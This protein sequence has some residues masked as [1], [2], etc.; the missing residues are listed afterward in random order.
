[1][2]CVTKEAA[3]AERSQC[4]LKLMSV[5]RKDAI[6]ARR[7]VDAICNGENPSSFRWRHVI[8]ALAGSHYGQDCLVRLMRNDSLA[9]ERFSDLL[10]A[11]HGVDDPN[12]RLVDHL[13]SVTM[14]TT[15]D[16]F[17]MDSRHAAAL[18]LGRLARKANERGDDPIARD[19]VAHLEA[20]LVACPV[21]DS[22]ELWSQFDDHAVVYAA[23]LGN[24]GHDASFVR[25]LEFAEHNQTNVRRAA[26]YG[27][28]HMTW[29]KVE[30]VYVRI[31]VDK[32]RTEA[33][34]LA[35]MDAMLSHA[36]ELSGEGVEALA[37][38]YHES[39][40][41]Y[42][43]VEKHLK[44]FFSTRLDDRSR[45]VLQRGRILTTVE[46]TKQRHLTRARRDSKL[47]QFLETALKPLVDQAFG[48]N[49]EFGKDFGA[50]KVKARFKAIFRNLAR[51]Y[52]SIFD[53]RVE[54]DIFNDVN[55][56]VSAFGLRF[57]IVHG[58]AAFQAGLSFKNTILSNLLN[59]VIDTAEKAVGS[60]RSA[61]APL[62]KFVV[63]ILDF[64]DDTFSSVDKILEPVLP[65]LNVMEQAIG[66]LDKAINVSNVAVD[67][68]N[69]I[70]S[71]ISRVGDLTFA[72]EIVQDLKDKL[73][74]FV[75]KKLQKLSDLCHSIIRYVTDPIDTLNEFVENATRIIDQITAIVDAI[76]EDVSAEFGKLLCD[77]ASALLNYDDSVKSDEEDDTGLLASLKGFVAKLAGVRGGGGS[78]PTM[79]LT[80]SPTSPGGGG[81]SSSPTTALTLSPTSP[82]GGGG[83]SSPTTASPGDSSSSSSS[84]QEILDLSGFFDTFIDY[85]R[86]LASGFRDGFKEGEA[87]GKKLAEDFKVFVGKMRGV[88]VSSQS[89]IDAFRDQLSGYTAVADVADFVKDL[90]KKALLNPSLVGKAL[91]PVKTAIT[92]VEAQVCGPIEK[93]LATVNRY[94]E[95]AVNT[96]Q[97]AVANL[98]D[99][100][101]G[102]LRNASAQVFDAFPVN[103]SLLSTV[104]LFEIIQDLMTRSI[105]KVSTFIDDAVMTRFNELAENFTNSIRDFIDS[106]IEDFA[107]VIDE[108]LKPM[109]KY[110]NASEEFIKFVQMA[111]DVNDVVAFVGEGVPE[112]VSLTGNINDVLDKT[113]DVAKWINEILGHISSSKSFVE[114]A[115]KGRDFV[116]GLIDE[117]FDKLRSIL[118]GMR[119][120]LLNSL[121]E[122]AAVA[123][124]YLSGG[125][126]FV[127]NII[128][129]ITSV[130]NRVN[131]F[132]DSIGLVKEAANSV[133]LSFEASCSFSG[134]VDIV[135][136]YEEK[137][138]G[139]ITCWNDLVNATTDTIG[140][141]LI[142]VTKTAVSPIEALA[143]KISNFIGRLI[144]LTDVYFTDLVGYVTQVCGDGPISPVCGAE[145]FI[146]DVESVIADAQAIVNDTKKIADLTAVVDKVNEYVERLENLTQR[147]IDKVTAVIDFAKSVSIADAVALGKRVLD[148]LLGGFTFEINLDLPS[149]PFRRRR[150][151]ISTD[152]LPSLPGRLRRE[153]D[154]AGFPF[155][156]EL[157]QLVQLGKTVWYEVRDVVLNAVGDVLQVANNFANA[158]RQM[159]DFFTTLSV[160]DEIFDPVL[161]IIN[162][163]E[164]LA[165]KLQAFLEETFFPPLEAATGVVLKFQSIVF[166]IK[167][168]INGQ[169][170][171]RIRS[172]AEFLS[173][174]APEILKTVRDW[175]AKLLLVDAG[176]DAGDLD[177][178]T[179]LDYCSAD[180]CVNVRPRS[181]NLYRNVVFKVKYTHLQVLQRNRV[182]IPGLFEDYQVEGIWPLDKSG[183]HFILSM[184][185]TGS[186]FQKP[187][188]LVV[189]KNDGTVLRLYRLYKPNGKILQGP[190]GVVI[191]E[192]WLYV[193]KINKTTKG[194]VVGNLY[195]ILK[196]ALGSMTTLSRPANVNFTLAENTDSMGTGMF[197]ENRRIWITDYLDSG[198]T[199]LGTTFP[200]HHIRRKNTQEAWVAA[201]RTDAKGKVAVTKY[202]PDK[203]QVLK[204]DRVVTVGKNVVGFSVFTQLG[205]T[206]YAIL[207]CAP[208][209]GFSCKLEFIEPWPGVNETY[210]GV[211]VRFGQAGVTIQRAVRM[212][213][214]AVDVTFVSAGEN[215]IVTFNSGAQGE[216]ARRLVTG[217]DLEDSTF[218]LAIPVLK[219]RLNIRDAVSRNELFLTVLGQD[220]VKPRELIPLTRSKR[221]TDLS[222]CLVGEGTLYEKE[223]EFFRTCQFGCKHR[224]I[225]LGV[226]FGIVAFLDFWALGNLEVTFQAA[227]CILEREARA[228]IIPRAYMTVGGQ[229]SIQA[230][231]LRVGIRIDVTL[232][233]TT[234]IPTLI[235]RVKGSVMQACGELKININP[236]SVT[237]SLVFDI[238]G[239]IIKCGSWK[240]WSCRIT[241]G[242]WYSKTIELFRW[243]ANTISLTPVPELCLSTPDRT[244]PVK[245]TV[246]AKQNDQQSL[247]AE[248]SDFTDPEAEYLHY[249]VT[250]R[251]TSGPTL[252]SNEFTDGA[253]LTKSGLT[254]QHGS[255]VIV[256]VECRNSDGKKTSVSAPSFFAD[257]TPPRVHGLV[258]G[259][260][261]S[262]DIDYG[263]SENSIKASFDQIT[264][265]TEVSLIEWGIGTTK[266]QDDVLA[267]AETK[268]SDDLA[269]NQLT[270]KHNT[271]YYVSIRAMNALGI[272]GITTTDGILIDHTN[273]VAGV[274]F[275]DSFTC[276]ED[277]D[278]QIAKESFK[279]CWMGF[280]DPES[281][282]H[283]YD[284]NLAHS[285]GTPEFDFIN[286]ALSSYGYIK[287]LNLI[288]KETYFVN[289]RAWNRAGLFTRVQSDGVLVDYTNPVCSQVFDVVDGVEGDS[290]YT[291]KLDSI[292]ATWTCSDPDSG[293][294]T[295]AA[296][297]GTFKGG[298][299]VLPF[300]D[301]GFSPNGTARVKFDTFVISGGVR[302]HVTSRVVNKAGL[303]STEWSD[304]ISLD[305]TP[306]DY[307]DIYVRD[308]AGAA[309]ALDVDF[310]V[311]DNTL[312]ARWFGAFADLQSP[313][314]T[315]YVTVVANNGSTIYEE[316]SIGYR[317]S[318]CVPDLSLETG[319]IYRV[320][321]RAENA[322]GLSTSVETDGVLIDNT[323]PMAGDL[324]DGQVVGED[325]DFWRFATS[326]FGN[327][328]S[329][330][331]YDTADFWPLDSLNLPEKQPCF[332]YQFR[333]EESGIGYLETNVI[334][335]TGKEMTTWQ[336]TEARFDWMGRTIAGVHNGFYRFA[337]RIYNGAGSFI[338]VY[339]NGSRIDTTPPEVTNLIE[340]NYTGV[341]PRSDIDYLTQDDIDVGASWD[342]TEDVS[343]IVHTDWAIGSYRGG[344]DWLDHTTVVGGD[345]HYMLTSLSLGRR[346]YIMVRV[347]NAAGLV[348]KVSTDGF[349]ID[350][351]AP[352]KGYVQDGWGEFDARYQSTNRTAWCKWRW[353]DDYESGIADMKLGIGSTLND[354]DDVY[355]EYKDLTVFDVAAERSVLTGLSLYSGILYYCH[356]KATDFVGLSTVSSSN[357]ITVDV[358]APICL[359]SVYEGYQNEIDFSAVRG[360]HVARWDECVDPDTDILQYL[361]G[362]ATNVTGPDLVL[363]YPFR[364]FGK[365]TVGPYLGV[366]L[367]H[368][369]TYYSAVR[370]VNFAGLT[371]TVISDGV[372]IDLTPPHCYSIGDGQEGDVD[373]ETQPGFIA[374]N[375]NCTEDITEINMTW[376]I[377]LY[378]G[379]S[380]LLRKYVDVNAG[381]A[382]NRDIILQEGVTLFSTLILLNTAG[383]RTVNTT[384]G[385][386]VDSTPPI[387][388]FVKDGLNTARD[389]DFQSSVSQI[390]ANWLISDI[391][392]GIL[393]YDVEIIPPP[394]S[395]N[396]VTKVVGANQVTIDAGLQPGG[397][398]QIKVTGYN[399]AGLFASATSDGI[400]IDP[401]PP[402]CTYVFDGARQGY[403]YQFQSSGAPLGVNWDCA[404]DESNITSIRWFAVN[405]KTSVSTEV[406]VD[407]D[408]IVAVASRLQL[409]EGDRFYARLVIENGAGLTKEFRSDGV[410]VDSSPPEI[411]DFTIV[412]D[413]T[414]ET[415]L[416]TWIA[417]D[418]ESGIAESEFGMGTEDGKYDVLALTSVGKSFSVSTK[419]YVVVTSP[420]TYYFYLVVANEASAK[421]RESA[422][423]VSDGTPPIFEG[424]VTVEIVYPA[425]NFADS[426]TFIDDAALLIVWQKISDV[427]TGVE[428]LSWALIN[429][430]SS[431]PDFKALTY[432]TL[433]DVLGGNSVQVDMIRLFNMNSY[434]VVLR[435][436]NGVGLQSYVASITFN[437]TFGAFKA[438]FVFDGPGY[439]DED[440]QPHTVGMWSRWEQF[441]DPVFGI[442]AY[443][444]G[445]GV[446]PNDTSILNLTNVELAEKAH[447]L[448]V[449]PLE[450]GVT[451]YITVVATNNRDFTVQAASDGITIDTT[452]A[453]CR[454]LGFG[455]SGNLEYVN[456]LQNVW[457][458]W[459]CSDDESP[460]AEYKFS[461]GT[462]AHFSDLVPQTT[463]APVNRYK[464]KT[465]NISEDTS[466]YLTLTVKNRAGLYFTETAGPVV[467]DFH[468]PNPGT[469][470][471]KWQDDKISAKWMDFRDESGLNRYEWAIGTSP[472]SANV[473]STASVG[474]S[475]SKVSPS[476][477]VQQGSLYYVTVTAYDM[478]ENFV[479]VQSAPVKGDLTV[480]VNGT[481]A[482][483][484]LMDEIDY[485]TGTGSIY[486]VWADFDDP[487]TGIAEYLVS[488]GRSPGASELQEPVSVGTATE[489]Y[490]DSERLTP[491]V[492][493]YVSVTAVNGIGLRTL[494]SSDGI[495]VDRTAPRAGSVAIEKTENSSMHFVGGTGPFTVKWKDF[496]DPES[497]IGYYV[498]SLCFEN[499]VEC[500]VPWENVQNEPEVVK[501]GLDLTPGQCYVARV[502]AYNKAGLWVQSMSESIVFDSTPPVMGTVTIGAKKHVTIQNDASAVT[503]VWSPIT[504]LDSGLQSITACIGTEP[505][506]C[507]VKSVDVTPTSRREVT[508]SGLSLT[509]AA[510]Y[511]AT[512]TVLNGA[513]LSSVAAS[514]GTIIDT[515]PPSVGTV[516]D[517]YT[518]IDIT[519][520]NFTTGVLSNWVD[521]FEDVST[522]VEYRWAIGTSTSRDD[523]LPWNSVGLRTNVSAN[524][525]QIASGTVVYNLVEAINS[526]GSNTTVASNGFTVDDTS[527]VI[528]SVKMG[529]R[530][531]P[532][533]RYELW[534][535]EIGAFWDIA[536]PETGILNVKWS[537]CSNTTAHHCVETLTNVGTATSAVSSS[538]TVT[539]GACYYVAVRVENCARLVSYAVSECTIFDNSAPVAGSVVDNE[540]GVNVEYQS[541]NTT[542]SVRWYG[543]GD[544]ESSI[545]YYSWC[546]GTTP[547]ANDTRQCVDVSTTDRASASGLSLKDGVQY[548]VAVY[549][550]N[551]VGLRS[552]AITDGVVVDSTPP[553][554]GQ[555]VIDGT[556][557]TD[558][559]SSSDDTTISASWDQFSDSVSLIKTCYWWAGSSYGA[560]DIFSRIDVGTATSASSTGYALPS[561]SFIYVCVEC[562][563]RAGL[564]ST[565][566]SDGYLIDTTPPGVGAALFDVHGATVSGYVLSADN[567]TLSWSGFY[568]TETE[569]SSYSFA[570]V[571]REDSATAE[572][573]DVSLLTN[574]TLSGAGLSDGK[575][576]RAK[577][578]AY[579]LVGLYSEIASADFVV[580]DGTSP[581]QGQVADG[582]LEEGNRMYQSN[583]S[584]LTA[585][586][587]EFA[588]AQSGIED[589]VACYG[590]DNETRTIG[591]MS[592]GLATSAD[593]FGLYLD[594]GLTY[595][596]TVTAVN[597]V[598]L[599]ST[600]RSDGVL[601]DFTPP[602]PGEVYDGINFEDI[603]YQT[604]STVVSASWTAFV[605]EESGIDFYTWQ[606]KLV[607]PISQQYIAETEAGAGLHA[608][609]SNFVLNPGSKLVACVSAMNRAGL[610]SEAFS[611]GVMVDTTPPIAGHV[612]DGEESAGY[613]QDYFSDDNVLRAWWKDFSDPES[614]ILGYTYTVYEHSFN[615]EGGFWSD[616][617]AV[618]TTT[619]LT[620]QTNVVIPLVINVTMGGRYTVEITAR[621][622][623]GLETS[624]VSDGVRQVPIE[625]CFSAETYD[626]YRFAVNASSS[627]DGI[628]GA[629]RLTSPGEVLCLSNYSH[630]NLPP[631]TGFSWTIFQDSGN[632]TTN[633]TA[634]EAIDDNA[635]SIVILNSTAIGAYT[636]TYSPCCRGVGE[637]PISVTTPDA[638]LSFVSLTGPTTTR[639]ISRNR[640]VV[641]NLQYVA[642]VWERDTS[643]VQVFPVTA[644]GDLPSVIGEELVIVVYNDKL[645]FF[646]ASSETAIQLEPLTLSAFSPSAIRFDVSPSVARVDPRPVE[647]VN[648][649]YP[650]E[651]ITIDLVVVLSDNS[652]RLYCGSVAFSSGA[653]IWQAA[654]D[655]ATT[656]NVQI[657]R[658]EF[659]QLAVAQPSAGVVTVYSSNR[660]SLSVLTSM[661]SATV[662]GFPRTL[663]AAR[664]FPHSNRIAVS[665]ANGEWNLFSITS[666]GVV[667]RLCHFN[668]SVSS[669]DDIM[670]IDETADGAHVL[671][672]V[673]DEGGTSVTLV[674]NMGD[675]AYC[676]HVG[677]IQVDMSNGARIT[678]A[679]IRDQVVAFAFNTTND[680][681]PR[682]HLA[683]FCWPNS[684]RSRTNA[685]EFSLQCRPCADGKRSSGGTQ[686]DCTTCAQSQ[687]LA[688]DQSY[689]TMW[690]SPLDIELD[691]EYHIEVTAEDEAGQ[692]VT[693]ES[694]T[695]TVDFTPPVAG[696]VYDGK[697]Q[698]DLDSSSMADFELTVSWGGFYDGESELKEYWWCVGTA[699]GLCDVVD[700]DSVS[701]TTEEV[702][703]TACV[704]SIGVWYYSTVVAVN[705]A[706]LNASSSSNGFIIDPTPPVVH[707]VRDGSNGSVDIDFQL[708]T[709][710]LRA[711]WSAHDS[712]SGISEYM[713]AVGTTPTTADVRDYKSAG[714][715][716]EWIVGD[717]VLEQKAT[718]YILLRVYNGAE[719][720]TF[721]ASD[722]VLIGKAEVETEEGTSIYLGTT[723]VNVDLDIGNAT[724]LPPGSEG[725]TGALRLEP[726]AS[727]P[728]II[729]TV[730]STSSSRRR[731]RST[732]QQIN[733]S[734]NIPSG[735][736]RVSKRFRVEDPFFDFQTTRL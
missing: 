369:V 67:F 34:K 37:S 327:Y 687:C 725:S 159:C 218:S 299:D 389:A 176:L 17:D 466:T 490:L 187:N 48:V 340:F 487:D 534:N 58:R 291:T 368:A 539:F 597:R 161:F 118:E 241:I 106:K 646:N 196:S 566:C 272:E 506:K 676:Q 155:M 435:A 208:K 375:W 183:T 658:N 182:F 608:I 205:E 122:A 556:G 584:H 588:D 189:Q 677:I 93:G 560:D 406:I 310:Q 524:G 144:Y 317:T 49:K 436:E 108:K 735:A 304:G 211:P 704:F 457:I 454:Y 505:E 441:R 222:N 642:F 31:I 446:T 301:V 530:S 718:Y 95:I 387:A 242:V 719:M 47:E 648:S 344:S 213:S 238:L 192:D 431:A 91:G 696:E 423:S 201:Y 688:E 302:Y 53:G 265:E 433:G 125:I 665:S 19:I 668:G 147:A 6:S 731:R 461:I 625:M 323:P 510:T 102:F 450:H 329:C 509:Q 695:L 160:P 546:I 42:P 235:L 202:R 726:D 421:S 96:S 485:Y 499:L 607:E 550:V 424:D 84:L 90:G 13:K 343:D 521:F 486:V 471:A 585:H 557:E 734:A 331:S 478:A 390:S 497:M 439:F 373:Y 571:A 334:D 296:A 381:V 26:I 73:N 169:I 659:G 308:G 271:I 104:D 622:R 273:P 703:C 437:V 350:Y 693:H 468:D 404:D 10:I 181:S 229:V 410:I 180:T 168:F 469:V 565:V 602:V 392:S 178:Y 717:L 616:G 517:G 495:L 50:D 606:V 477:D 274:V 69:K 166:D 663:T 55:A 708:S 288:P 138:V 736:V 298:S 540:D 259:P 713:I 553:V 411:L 628:G 518:T 28:R 85:A 342:V 572:Y 361:L 455:L 5:I 508:I 276:D 174:K 548:F 552:V 43:D 467:F 453:Y 57:D 513:G 564:T 447:K 498:W 209:P 570:M 464:I 236:L 385:I 228:S 204:P 142:E 511:Y 402:N 278:Y 51:V 502:K 320:I 529:R 60:V 357:G 145:L 214:G 315:Y 470:T 707:F 649:R 592:V 127:Q 80:S 128:D 66:F 324:Y 542:L 690:A 203:T 165:M 338:E 79:A 295:F 71:F 255:R 520:Q 551:K 440:Y 267:Y 353:I 544:N 587:F 35:A 727:P 685:R 163:A 130:A 16:V 220:V 193:H 732:I 714:N 347:T 115:T 123:I 7:A 225:N 586:W 224:S 188:I 669:Y 403:D 210:S 12:P 613:E 219:N 40:V 75:K 1:M 730:E 700:F 681:S 119:D 605:D 413:P 561:G 309:R 341:G 59:T 444:W 523:I 164:K 399:G 591:C 716:V 428:T 638:T 81:G 275:D 709:D 363:A 230:A 70:K 261:G 545:D 113:L 258:D 501:E 578:R 2:N 684:A 651:T 167:E 194:D 627:E 36:D 365:S 430:N 250:A 124:E 633:V 536:D 575:T 367:Q 386:A 503:V 335:N 621:N 23:A 321:V 39:I 328:R 313:I 555:Q 522:I 395:G 609:G 459:N 706:R 62:V 279:A 245:G 290:D 247:T 216:Q 217:A 126:E 268:K 496:I 533:E 11:T 398:Y 63:K 139:M 223:I 76:P 322:A 643:K 349:I 351:V 234:L 244:A 429:T 445:V 415:F 583:D 38:L 362:I 352:V 615:V 86:S 172:A 143:E 484:S 226:Y 316:A 655:I 100:V 152:H 598:G 516:I 18:S 200:K 246:E 451:Y 185:V 270:L 292:T 456:S 686:D 492:W 378:P 657:S 603:D 111:R 137:F 617:I 678:S 527:P 601:I 420:T 282:I 493:Y 644:S 175:L 64:L 507:D 372:T 20:R 563:N 358:S 472:G 83:G 129:G 21:H 132:I 416:L 253:T 568:E 252:F 158:L 289:L 624:A 580:L 528:S 582:K 303:Y 307:A 206:F 680:S 652:Y 237:L 154:L 150:R 54:F 121:R 697:N 400:T 463:I 198:K 364:S 547:G 656:N 294:D 151:E 141:G 52:L 248:W 409:A 379:G 305:D 173:V 634:A 512:L 339:S 306:P 394:L 359:G 24:A 232:M 434:Q 612:Y 661:S 567:L 537:I 419:D 337:L 231:L 92:K 170:L 336:Y 277:K 140:E 393:Y 526:A 618:Q 87:A 417:R 251:S 82:A 191:A 531:R 569:I 579:N 623:A 318:T 407:K 366:D 710:Y 134:V 384:D 479:S 207:R 500:V 721:A 256:T 414:G 574:V 722:G 314:R 281:F 380:S 383:L 576:Y 136:E 543:F 720:F 666:S 371:T 332:T 481:V 264:D 382:I 65:F 577:I 215:L 72:R 146:D 632:E 197:Y 724:A 45:E 360:L 116:T 29:T 458:S 186:N 135:V 514:E 491:G 626:G 97:E 474:L 596:V 425:R 525:L 590:L 711:Y 631:R 426:E 293:L 670:E 650:N 639:L 604:T 614:G 673:S 630:L 645:L 412:Y 674:K 715:D 599:R 287:D 641:A 391:Q 682:L 671:N 712:E 131:G 396:T 562:E 9:A 476:I 558:I 212:P 733:P 98:T 89:A 30:P 619:D 227:L 254:F 698:T 157:N 593:F 442:K 153:I 554:K 594:N 600:S 300:S 729:L 692:L 370:A 32:N 114:Y 61:L 22:N 269:N 284:W 636:P 33:E 46:E 184:F 326:A 388:S 443:S 667:G 286:V 449:L 397:F 195:G 280:S 701:G 728:G 620:E 538:V 15:S 77:V 432:R 595:A 325:I 405:D 44:N 27:M 99:K 549:A 647:I 68:I 465:L 723:P 177:D 532:Y 110:L 519:Y 199:S 475:T 262:S 74:E 109:Q 418:N 660:G 422:I 14:T 689:I 559:D 377:G 41:R 243:S 333:D 285:T 240:P 330:L 515:T 610:K 691:G 78:S 679:S 699:P 266:G 103:V 581:D 494:V 239:P 56:Y 376:T 148:A 438:G 408:A 156:K 25:L 221:Q 654:T 263:F 427:E 312:C 117:G 488:V 489:Y 683:S 179:T 401:T 675:R 640:F 482:E 149:L 346:Y 319:A 112:I 573:I 133:S 283:Y 635:T 473:L 233:D 535:E 483:G 460:I 452:P 257:T 462:S 354:T 348:T 120:K 611:D 297:V 4:I 311:S 672:A 355:G 664:L 589:F 3:V 702:V 356:V 345:P 629:I 162:E 694:Q 171:G 541:S 88:L 374:V 653:S 190:I 705:W 8:Q 107:D 448:N 637:L 260:K 105:E 662:F 504:D 480:P 94:V 249:Y 101:Q